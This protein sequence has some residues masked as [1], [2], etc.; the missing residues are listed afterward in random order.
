M[1]D[2]SVSQFDEFLNFSDLFLLQISFRG[3]LIN[4]RPRGKEFWGW[5]FENR[6]QFNLIEHFL[7]PN[8]MTMDLFLQFL[9]DEDYAIEYFTWKSPSGKIS[10]P[11]RAFFR[12]SDIDEN[13]KHLLIFIKNQLSDIKTKLPIE[14]KKYRFQAKNLP[15]FIHNMNG[16]LSSILGRVELLQ[17]KYPNIQEFEEIVT[18]GYKL[19][20]V[21]DNL[22]FK[23]Q[24]ECDSE[25]TKV[26]LN[27]LLT[28]EMKF[29]NC[30]LFFKHHVE[31]I[32][33]FSK[34]IPDFYASYFS[35]SGVLSESYQF[36]RQF[37]DEQK[38]Y[39]F[40]LKSF[41]NN[42]DVG[43]GFE[44]TGEFHS[45]G[46]KGTILPFNLEGGALEMTRVSSPNLDKDF[47]TECL[48]KNK[49][50]LSLNCTKDVIKF[51]MKFPLPLD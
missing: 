24:N 11:H 22:S 36:V 21:T 47:L 49:A 12:S 14:E 45:P 16:P 3:D 31:K 9:E 6:L 10:S 43:L 37:V 34:N 17:L 26:N 28:E 33:E 35:I 15:G 32:N 29:L 41:K 7:K 25:K 39:L 27:R 44:F 1:N 4:F 50:T 20:S 2:L 42:N 19:Q 13:N 40:K 18:V 23:I 48:E 38:E 8:H 51:K 30:D 5:S 46:E